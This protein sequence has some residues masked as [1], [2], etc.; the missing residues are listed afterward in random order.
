MRYRWNFTTQ[1]KEDIVSVVRL[2][3][4]PGGVVSGGRQRMAL[5]QKR[6][7]PTGLAFPRQHE[8][9]LVDLPT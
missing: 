1:N 2:Q 6:R 7:D 3:P 8:D 4:Y 5:N 9:S